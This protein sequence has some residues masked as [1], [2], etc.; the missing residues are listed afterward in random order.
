LATREVGILDLRHASVIRK[1]IAT[2]PSIRFDPFL[3]ED[4]VEFEDAVVPDSCSVEIILYGFK[5][6]IDD[7]DSILSEACIFLQEPTHIE[8]HVVY[9][10]PHI[11]S[12]DG[13]FGS[14]QFKNHRLLDPVNVEEEAKA[15][16]TAAEPL[17][18]A[19]ETE[20]QDPR[21]RAVL[22]RLNR[23]PQ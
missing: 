20:G 13:D 15:I 8:P 14:P 7:V 3:A 9:H 5:D 17:L 22:H 6:T 12:W 4:P 19:L 11:L 18:L 16:V 2:V 1:L 21:I 10:N 23:L